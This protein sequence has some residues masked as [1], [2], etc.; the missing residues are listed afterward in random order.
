M[1]YSKTL[2][3][4]INEF[5]NAESNTVKDFNDKFYLSPLTGFDDCDTL[6]I[7]EPITSMTRIVIVGNKTIHLDFRPLRSEIVEEINEEEK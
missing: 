3:I 7:G 2:G 4:M 5:D 1:Q 6:E